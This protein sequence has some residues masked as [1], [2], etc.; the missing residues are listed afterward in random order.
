MSNFSLAEDNSEKSRLVLCTN[1]AIK[2][3]ES[4]LMYVARSSLGNFGVAN[5]FHLGIVC[6][7]EATGL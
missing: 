7:M 3:L 4:C 5:L 1:T 6:R 2:E